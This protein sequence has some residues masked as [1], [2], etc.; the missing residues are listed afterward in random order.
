MT[1]IYSASP[2]D[3]AAACW[4]DGIAVVMIR[5]ARGCVGPRQPKDIAVTPPTALITHARTTAAAHIK[6]EY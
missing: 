1:S 4:C 6:N 5:G 2:R 3:G